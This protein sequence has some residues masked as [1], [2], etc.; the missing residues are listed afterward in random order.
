MR[1]PCLVKAGDDNPTIG[2]LLCRNKKKIET[3]F[4]LRGVSQPIGVSE[5]TLTEEL[6]ENLKGS[7]PTV[8][9]IE[10]ELEEKESN[11]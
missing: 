8:G 7:L 6:P 4:A 9:E 3:E 11:E 1:W 2:I 5:F 10:S